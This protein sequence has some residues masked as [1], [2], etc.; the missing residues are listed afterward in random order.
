MTIKRLTLTPF[1]YI[2]SNLSL[3]F[4]GLNCELNIDDCAGHLCQNGGKC[5]DKVNTYSCDCPPEWTGKYCNEDVDECVDNP[6]ENG[7]TCTNE[8]GG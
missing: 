6:C 5:I 8:Q 4:E 2:I 7:A 3:G 1:I